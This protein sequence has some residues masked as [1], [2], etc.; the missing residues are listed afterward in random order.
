MVDRIWGMGA[1]LEAD[2]VVLDTAP[3]RPA[4]MGTNVPRIEALGMKA[5]D[6]G[7]GGR[8]TDSWGVGGWADRD[9]VVGVAQGVVAVLGLC[10]AGDIWEADVSGVTWDT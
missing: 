7:D 9:A 6:W 8:V 2:P 4:D 3:L 1:V 10:G 5:W